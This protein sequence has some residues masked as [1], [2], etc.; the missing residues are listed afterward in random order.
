M[1]QVCYNNINYRD[2]DSEANNL[3]VKYE[4][5]KTMEINLLKEILNH[6]VDSAATIVTHSNNQPHIS[7]TWNSFITLTEDEKLLIPVGGMNLTEKN[8]L[9]NDDVLLSISNRVVAGK[10]FP[11]TG[12]VIEGKAYIRTSG[13]EFDLVKKQFSWIRGALVVEIQSI[14]QTI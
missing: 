13:N 2:D 9:E 6:K 10:N 14:K 7:N 1:I 8:L 12:V 5:E 11:G 3:T 4:K